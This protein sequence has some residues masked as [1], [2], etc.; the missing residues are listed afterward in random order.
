MFS[1]QTTFLIDSQGYWC[2]VRG[3]GKQIPHVTM[4]HGKG[5]PNV[6]YMQFQR[7]KFNL[8]LLGQH[9]H[10]E[11]S[12]RHS[13]FTRSAPVVRGLISTWLFETTSTRDLPD[14]GSIMK[15]PVICSA[16]GR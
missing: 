14:K 3:W 15:E 4:E 9:L 16:G 12:P 7:R 5:S 11:F 2:G 6:R 1:N 10:G 13:Y 8:L